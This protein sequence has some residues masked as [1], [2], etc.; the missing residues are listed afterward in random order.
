VRARYNLPRPH[1]AS[2]TEWL[3]QSGFSQRQKKTPPGERT[4]FSQEDGGASGGW[5]QA[6]LRI[7]RIPLRL[8]SSAWANS[9]HA[10]C[11]EHSVASTL[12]HFDAMLKQVAPGIARI[13]G[14]LTGFARFPPRVNIVDTL[15]TRRRRF[16]QATTRNLDRAGSQMGTWLFVAMRFLVVG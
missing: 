9:L 1:K 14:H 15:R 16:V 10:R 6:V 7:S 8:G 11:A 12:R 5:G 4:G 13:L 3:A 2:F